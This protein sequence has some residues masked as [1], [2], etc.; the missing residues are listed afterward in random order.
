MTISGGNSG[1]IY[2]VKIENEF[3]EGLRFHRN[4]VKEAKELQVLDDLVTIEMTNN[5]GGTYSASYTVD[6]PGKIIIS[7]YEYLKEEGVY[8]QFIDDD[9]K[10]LLWHRICFH[11]LYSNW[12]YGLGKTITSPFI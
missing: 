11:K 3:I 4:I 9:S 1:G 2:L 5:G 6:R 8:W 12:L 7:S 10:K